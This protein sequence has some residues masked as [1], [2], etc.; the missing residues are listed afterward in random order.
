MNNINYNNLNK[1]P[2]R[3]KSWLKVNDVSLKDYNA[4]EIGEF[5]NYKVTG[6]ELE[7]VTIEEFSKGKVLPLTKEFTY[8]ASE[9]LINQGELDFNRGFYK[10][11]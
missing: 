2:V 9:E 3:T 11:R 6:N 4:P 10:N 5:N 1:T 8:G 7:G